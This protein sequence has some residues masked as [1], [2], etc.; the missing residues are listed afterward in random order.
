MQAGGWRRPPALTLQALSRLPQDPFL[1][2]TAP[3]GRGSPCPSFA[4]RKQGQ[5]EGRRPARR[6]Q[7]SGLKPGVLAFSAASDRGARGAAGPVGEDCSSGGAG[8]PVG[9]SLHPESFGPGSRWYCGLRGAVDVDLVS[10]AEGGQ[11]SRAACVGC[12]LVRGSM[13]SPGPAGAGHRS[14]LPQPR[15]RPHLQS[16]F[17]A[18]LVALAEASW[19]PVEGARQA[20]GCVCPW[21]LVK[22][23]TLWAAVRGGGQL[24][25]H[26]ELTR[27]PSK[28]GQA[29]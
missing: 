18:S 20:P 10:F 12:G 5:K 28:R 17:T 1:L 24:G 15:A 8:L 16:E 25:T 2:P 14:P 6:G 29:F 23:G 26:L 13:R 9:S 22:G 4:V 21:M 27:C 19:S 7:S 11:G 3:R